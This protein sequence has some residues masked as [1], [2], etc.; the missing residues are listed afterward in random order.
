MRSLFHCLAFVALTF[1]LLGADTPWNRMD[2]GSFLSSSVTL[3]W[4]K[5]GE[6]LDGIVLKG[7]TFRFGTNGSACFDTGELRWAC[8]WTGGWL[9]LMGTPF[10]GTHRPPDR[11]RPAAEGTPIFG[12]SHG[13]GWAHEGDWRDPRTEPYIPLPREWAKYRGLKDLESQVVLQ[14]T[15]GD[16]FV[17]E[18][19]SLKVVEGVPSFYRTI[20]IAPHSK[21]M[22]VLVDELRLEL[23]NHVGFEAHT[24]PPDS[25]IHPLGDLTAAISAMPPGA[26]WEV[27]GGTRLVLNLP[28]TSRTTTFTLVVAKTQ[29]DRM[30]S[31]LA[32]ADAGSEG[33]TRLTAESRGTKALGPYSTPL[34]PT[35]TIPGKLG[36]SGGAFE[37]DTLPLPEDNPWHAW[38]RPGGFD[39]FADGTRAAV[40]TWSG[41]VWLVSG[42]DAGLQHVT[43]QRFATGLFQPLGLKIVRDQVYVLCRDQIARLIDR[44]GDG[45]ADDYECFN[46]DVSVTPNFHEFALDLQADSAGNFFFTKGAP[47]LGTDYWDPIGAHNGSVVK[48]SADGS[49]LERFATGLR[50]PNGSG[51]GPHD[52]LT[53][54]DNEGIWTP[55][56]RLNWVRPGGFYGA[57]GMDHRST[58]PSRSDPPICWLPFAIDNSSG[59]QVWASSKFGALSGEL[60]HLSYGKCRAFHVLRQSVGSTIQ[61]GVVPLPWRFD[62]SAMR[63]RINPADGSLWVGG[64]K[65]WQT[66][67]TRDGALHRVRSTGTEF[68]TLTGFRVV[69]DGFELD[70]NTPLDRTAAMDPQSWDVQWWNY[71]WSY[72]YGSDLYSIARPGEKTGRKG[73]LKGDAATVEAIQLDPSAQHVKLVVSHVPIAMQLAIRG[74]LK[75]QIGTE[76]PLEYYGTINAI[77]R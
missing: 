33:N 70:F 38:M 46:N 52:E 37:V 30:P 5:N 4:S 64:F 25:R 42:I 17:A 40:C 63:G 9:K 8:V 47:L 61:G 77:P 36:N 56:C 20:S 10:D 60:I 11:S 67:A 62:S 15:I 72:K 27:L 22:A 49:R 50:A 76:L 35:F 3:P 29:P 7:T 51:L 1:P 23:R 48:V 53:C 44:N 28:K 6:D 26:Q 74:T 65:G 58:T 21:P 14:Y 2:Y 16:A 41:D 13:P 19:P 66:T 54:S 34:K 55:V 45:T 18:V 39:F 69:H 68:P 24:P 57:I 31:I 75:T 59:G 32:K 73:E 12:T 71:L 43:W